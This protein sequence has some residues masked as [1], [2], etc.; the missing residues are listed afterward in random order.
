MA[1]PAES[2]PRSPMQTNIGVSICPSCS[3]NSVVLASKP[4]MPHIQ[5]SS[6]N[7]PVGARSGCWRERFQG[8]FIAEVL[9]PSYQVALH[10]LTVKFLKVVRSQVVIGLPT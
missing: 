5:L 3:R 1:R 7:S 4:T 10:A 9:Q 8:D 6:E 2:E